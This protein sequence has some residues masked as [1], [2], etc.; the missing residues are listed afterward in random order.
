MCNGK[1]WLDRESDSPEKRR[2][3][4]ILSI[5]KN[6]TIGFNWLKSG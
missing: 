2:L 3:A 5:G 1:T 6:Y 4:E